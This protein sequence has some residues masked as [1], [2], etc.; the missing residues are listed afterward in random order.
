[1]AVSKSTPIK[2]LVHGAA[3]RVGAEVVRAVDAASGM[4][5]VAAVDRIA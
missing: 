2:V 5:L 1:M 4:A 3:G